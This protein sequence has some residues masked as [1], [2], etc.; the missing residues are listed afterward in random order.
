MDANLDV[1]VSVR[2]HIV[3]GFVMVSPTALHGLSLVC[4]MNFSAESIPSLLL[5]FFF[6]GR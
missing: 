1:I 6:F 3:L 5:L 4:L 2:S